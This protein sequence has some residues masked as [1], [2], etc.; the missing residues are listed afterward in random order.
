MR[1]AHQNWSWQRSVLIQYS[2]L[3]QFLY[4]LFRAGGQPIVSTI[5]TTDNGVIKF[6]DVTGKESGGYIC[7]ASN[8]MGSVTATATLRI[9]GKIQ[10]WKRN[11][12]YVLKQNFYFSIWNH[13]SNDC[14]VF[15][16]FGILTAV[17]NSQMF[18][19]VDQMY[20]INLLLFTIFG[21]SKLKRALMVKQCNQ[22]ILQKSLVLYWHCSF[23]NK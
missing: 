23:I 7:T 12:I 16:Y 6:K 5:D 1:F 14:G 2:I 9:T 17:Q 21:I 15:F 8:E 22:F 11:Y 19:A 10:V 18:N 3:I 13:I 4:S 20:M